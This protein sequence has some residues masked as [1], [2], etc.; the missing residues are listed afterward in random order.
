MLR[1]KKRG[2][3]WCV[4]SPIIPNKQYKTG[5]EV[6]FVPGVGYVTKGIVLPIKVVNEIIE[7]A[8]DTGAKS[9][10]LLLWEQIHNKHHNSI[11]TLMLNAQGNLKLVSCVN[12]ENAVEIFEH[13]TKIYGEDDDKPNSTTQYKKVSCKLKKDGS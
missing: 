6:L 1:H 8:G 11:F 9:G 3:K 5:D 2:D 13:L 4:N 12:L 7:T 10:F